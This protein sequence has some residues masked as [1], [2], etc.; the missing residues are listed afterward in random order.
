MFWNSRRDA[1]ARAHAD[2]IAAAAIDNEAI[3]AAALKYKFI[4][5]EQA[6][7]MR[8]GLPSL[9][10]DHTI[11]IFQVNYWSH[12]VSGFFVLVHGWDD[13]ADPETISNI[14]SDFA[15]LGQYL[16]DHPAPPWASGEVDY[17]GLYPWTPR[18][19]EQQP[20]HL[21]PLAYLGASTTFL[22]SA[23]NSIP[24]RDEFQGE[25]QEQFGPFI[26]FY[27]Y[28]KHRYSIGPNLPLPD[29]PLPLE[30]KKIFRDWA[31]GKVN[32]IGATP[33]SADANGHQP[34]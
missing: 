22:I 3:R 1:E 13:P 31:E 27:T 33:D 2:A 34:E 12:L 11:G 25:E 15:A 32:F 8:N 26:D 19:D 30:F 16:I 18:V 14:V 29:P 6:L 9:L 17:L 23:E 7:G 5:F 20:L 24:G 4:T 21:D 10:R 28:I